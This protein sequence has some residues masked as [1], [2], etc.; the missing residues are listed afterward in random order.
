MYYKFKILIILLLKNIKLIKN[1]ALNKALFF[2]FYNTRII[3]YKKLKF[4]NILIF[5]IKITKKKGLEP[6]TKVLETCILPIKLFFLKNRLK[7][8]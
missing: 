5:F 7:R 6:L 1:L 4:L 3:K 8:T 2:T